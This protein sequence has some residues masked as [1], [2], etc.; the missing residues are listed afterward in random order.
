MYINGL[1]IE[2]LIPIIEMCKEY[3]DNKFTCDKDDN[4]GDDMSLEDVWK[5]KIYDKL[6]YLYHNDKNDID[7]I[8]NDLYAELKELNKKP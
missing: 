8:T 1:P 2:A 7:S 3:F 6:L 4:C 5:K